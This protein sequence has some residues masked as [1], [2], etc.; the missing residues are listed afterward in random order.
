MTYSVKQMDGGS[1]SEAFRFFFGS[2]IFIHVTFL[3]RRE[4]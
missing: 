2:I 1:L 3:N 4:T